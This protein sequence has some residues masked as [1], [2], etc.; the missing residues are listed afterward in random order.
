M[1][2]TAAMDNETLDHLLSVVDDSRNLGPAGRIGKME[3]RACS[4]K[5]TQPR[6]TSPQPKSDIRV[7][8]KEHP[9][10]LAW[11]RASG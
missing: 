3:L 5:M 8:L 6:F 9:G 1:P 11:P 4:G 7:R 2:A 10:M